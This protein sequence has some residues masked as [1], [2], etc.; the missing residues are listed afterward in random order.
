MYFSGKI[1]HSVLSYLSQTGADLD[2]IYEKTELPAEFLRDPSCWLEADKVES[3]LSQLA[4]NYNINFPGECLVEKAGHASHELRSWGV[5]NSVLKMMMHPQDLYSQPQRF[6]SYF[7]SPAPPIGDF[8]KSA[9]KVSFK[10][11]ISKEEHPYV[12]DYLRATFE[13][14]PTFMSRPM[15]KATWELNQIEISWETNQAQLF[16][17]NQ[18]LTHLSPELLQSMVS[19]VE[20]SE[21]ALEEKIKECK[22]K[23]DRIQRLELELMNGVSTSTLSTPDSKRLLSDVESLIK[24]PMANAHNQLLR[25]SDY[26]TRAQQLITLLVGQ[27]RMDKQVKAAMKRMDWEQV[28]SRFTHV[29]QEGVDNLE[30]IKR[31]LESYKNVQELKEGSEHLSMNL[32]SVVERAISKASSHLRDKDIQVARMLFFDRDLKM[33]PLS[34]E[35]LVG[36]LLEHSS[37]HLQSKGKIRI[38]TRPRGSFAE[39]EISDNSRSVSDEDLQMIRKNEELNGIIKSHNG[40]LKIFND[41]E[42]GSTYLIDLP[43]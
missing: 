12:S 42:V 29:V 30:S 7:I 43:L 25:M 6:I 35:K 8:Q 31:Q 37:D 40:Q 39:I 2:G 17:P 34:I 33:C 9:S 10:L 41:R 19:A 26:M 3:F 21:K 11:P 27:D 18:D 28:R 16:E 14:L 15:A 1:T 20:N 4:H 22:E 13:S 38:V 36:S 23:D 5:L 32:D 24:A